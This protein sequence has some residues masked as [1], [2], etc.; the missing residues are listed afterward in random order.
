[1]NHNHHVLEVLDV[2]DALDADVDADAEVDAD[3][4]SKPWSWAPHGGR[5]AP[6][7]P[8]KMGPIWPTSGSYLGP[9]GSLEVPMSLCRTYAWTRLRLKMTGTRMHPK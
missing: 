7:P 6:E 5:F 3:A 4:D 9:A 1:M 8:L 2:L